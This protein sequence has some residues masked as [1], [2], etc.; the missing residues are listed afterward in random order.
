MSPYADVPTPAH[1]FGAADGSLYVGNS[2]NSTAGVSPHRVAPGGAPVEPLGDRPIYDPD[3]VA[4]DATGAISGAAG[5]VLVGAIATP[6]SSSGNI[7]AI[8]PSGTIDPLFSGPGWNIQEMVFDSAGRMLIAE[9]TT[10]AILVSSGAAPQEL[11]SLPAVVAVVT[12]DA[13][14]RI[15]TCD[16]AGVVR[17]HSSA[18]VEIDPSYTTFPA[19]AYIDIGR[20]AGFGAAL[21][22]LDTSNGRIYRVASDGMK[23]EIARG[24]DVAPS[25]DILDIGFGADGALYIAYPNQNR[26]WRLTA[27]GADCDGSGALDF[28][29]FLCFQN[30]FAVGDPYADCDAT[31]VL[32]FFDFL[33][34]Q[35]LFAGGCS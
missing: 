35:N 1:I 23:T 22:G 14:D 8:R 5:S 3:G 29:D 30:L 11:F 7:W 27:C 20:G 26:I 9:P 15:Y 24:F 4:L 18:G 16:D 25:G 2:D 10:R 17:I 19:R 6:G 34:F 32:D 33:C 13:A 28:F 12:V 31:G 21:Y